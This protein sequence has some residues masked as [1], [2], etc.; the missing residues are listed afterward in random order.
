MRKFKVETFQSFLFRTTARAPSYQLTFDPVTR[1]AIAATIEVRQ[2]DAPIGTATYLSEKEDLFLEFSANESALRFRVSS[3]TNGRYEAV[4]EAADFSETLIFGADGAM[5]FPNGTPSKPVPAD[6]ALRR[7]IGAMAD[8]REPL[9]AE[10]GLSSSPNVVYQQA[11]GSGGST[12]AA[13]CDANYKNTLQGIAGDAL[14]GAAFGAGLALGGPLGA[15]AGLVVVGGT[16]LSTNSKEN[17]AKEDHK[18]CLANAT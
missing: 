12:T 9:Q 7:L 16:Y 6:P 5:E 8:F 3:A 13:Q 2:G 17:K 1:Q 14:A 10:I 15:L 11:G 4:V 18:E